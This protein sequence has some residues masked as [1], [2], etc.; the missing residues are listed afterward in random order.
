MIDEIT[1]LKNNKDKK[2]WEYFEK[3]WESAPDSISIHYNIGW[4]DLCDLC[5][6]NWVFYEEES[7][8]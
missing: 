6:E 4:Y 1:N 3:A 8:G 5:S 7:I 2:L